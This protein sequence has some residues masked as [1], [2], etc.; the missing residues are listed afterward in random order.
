LRGQL[1]QEVS[2]GKHKEMEMMR[3]RKTNEQLAV[4]KKYLSR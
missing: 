3:L 4:D 2:E 1:E